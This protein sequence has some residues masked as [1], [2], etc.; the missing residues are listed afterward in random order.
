[1][2]NSKSSTKTRRN[3]EDLPAAVERSTVAGSTQKPIR[4]KKTTYGSS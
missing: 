1:M 3:S 4:S 2:P